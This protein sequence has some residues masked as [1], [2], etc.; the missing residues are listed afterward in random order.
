GTDSLMRGDEAG[1]GTP[2]EDIATLLA[3]ESLDLPRY[4]VCLGFGIDA[5]HGVCHAHFLE[6]TAELAQSDAYLGTFSVLRDQEEGRAYLELVDFATSE[7]PTH[8]SIVNTSIAASL[9]GHF[10]DHHA[11]SRTRGSELFI[12]PLMGIY[13]SYEASAV[14]DRILYKDLVRPTETFTQLLVLIESV[15]KSHAGKRE[16]RTLPV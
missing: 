15:M 6:N 10:G 7:E 3:I 14:I 9:Q 1:L 13:W 11:T 2:H 12:N 8:P 16:R 5:F 4:L